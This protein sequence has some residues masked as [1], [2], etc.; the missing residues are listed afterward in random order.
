MGTEEHLPIPTRAA[1]HRAGAP[2][3][4]GT[5]CPTYLCGSGQSSVPGLRPG[6]GGPQ[7]P[8]GRR[9]RAWGGVWGCRPGSARAPA[10]PEGLRE[11]GLALPAA[12]ARGQPT[13]P[14][15]RPGRG[16]ET[17]RQPGGRARSPRPVAAAAPRRHGGPRGGHGGMAAGG[18]RT[19]RNSSGSA[20][21]GG[22][23]KGP[24]AAPAPPLTKLPAR[25]SRRPRRGAAIPAGPG[26]RAG[27]AAPHGRKGPE[28]SPTAA[29]PIPAPR[30]GRPQNAAPRGRG[31]KRA[32][33]AAPLPAPTLSRLGRP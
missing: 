25:G 23:T 24:A 33:P 30:V 15:K 5:L 20:G 28:G 7:V 8:H 10:R 19:R 3:R 14:N 29:P 21:G 13:A 6:P 9:S 4:E 12:Q 32:G 31:T 17:S 22:G 26:L 27:A 18:R 11:P 1:G 2:R 16:S